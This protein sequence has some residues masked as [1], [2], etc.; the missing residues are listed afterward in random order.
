[1]IWTLNVKFEKKENTTC[2]LDII[3]WSHF[4]SHMTDIHFHILDY[5]YSPVIYPSQVNDN[6]QTCIRS[7]NLLPH[8]WI[9]NFYTFFT[10]YRLFSRELKFQRRK[11]TLH[12]LH[13]LTYCLMTTSLWT[14]CERKKK[15]HMWTDIVTSFHIPWNFSRKRFTFMN[16][17]RLHVIDLF[18]HMN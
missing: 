12:L 15:N 3:K 5:I 6:F 18:P 14:I 7:W 4:F 11:T 13:S 16:H 2:N 1:M 8:M 10:F 9:S 17:F